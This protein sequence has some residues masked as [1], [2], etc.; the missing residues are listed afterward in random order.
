M[1]T[2]I[3][4]SLSAESGGKRGE[5]TTV[6]HVSYDVPNA[7]CNT[8]LVQ[9][10]QLFENNLERRFCITMT[11]GLDTTVSPKFHSYM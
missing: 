8:G 2:E 10:N 1:S 9:N 4:A 3:R 6:R 7:N 5:I 11:I